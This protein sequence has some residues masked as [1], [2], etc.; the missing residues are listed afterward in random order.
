MELASEWDVF[1]SH[2]VVV[3]HTDILPTL[4]V[5]PVVIVRARTKL[6]DRAFSV[7]ALLSAWSTEAVFH[8]PTGS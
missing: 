7:A 5:G 2:S 1:L 4:C 8:R 6:G 3:E